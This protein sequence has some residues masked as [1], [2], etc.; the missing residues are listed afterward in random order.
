M[1]SSFGEK[2]NQGA[3]ANGFYVPATGVAGGFRQFTNNVKPIVT[4]D[5]MKGLKMRTPLSGRSSMW[6]PR[7]SC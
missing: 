6:P 7:S 4:P 5:D 3:V 2:L 1:R